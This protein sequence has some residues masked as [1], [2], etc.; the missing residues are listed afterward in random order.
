MSPDAVVLL[1]MNVARNFGDCDRNTA[2]L[3][4]RVEGDRGCVRRTGRAEPRLKP[5]PAVLATRPLGEGKL[6]SIAKLGGLAH[7]IT[8]R[9]FVEPLVW[10]GS[11][12]GC[13][14]QIFDMEASVGVD[15]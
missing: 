11:S 8:I 13:T 12:I 15:W 14:M 1:R 5:S 3:V 4:A 9:I 2:L 6:A 10:V 7:V